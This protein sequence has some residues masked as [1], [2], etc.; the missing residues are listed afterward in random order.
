MKKIMEMR[1][2]KNASALIEDTSSR[3]SAP[4]GIDGGGVGGGGG[5]LKTLVESVSHY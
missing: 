4:S 2:K 1:T 5:G 3:H